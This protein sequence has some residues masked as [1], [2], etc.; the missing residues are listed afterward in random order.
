[1]KAQQSPSITRIEAQVDVSD[2]VAL[3]W[4]ESGR[5]GS[6]VWQRVAQDH[7]RVAADEAKRRRAQLLRLQGGTGA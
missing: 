7:A 5:D 4:A 3:A 6:P 2:Q 1:M